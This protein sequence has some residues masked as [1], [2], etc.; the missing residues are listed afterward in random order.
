MKRPTDDEPE[1]TGNDYVSLPEIHG[2]GGVGRVSVLH[3]S[4]AGLVEW[5]GAGPDA[6]LFMPRLS[7]GGQLMTLP[8]LRWRRLDRWIPTFSATLPGDLTLTGTICAP[9]G[10]PAARGFFIRLELDNRGRAPVE[11]TASLAV[12]WR[13]SLHW[14]ATPRPL[15]GA[16]RLALLDD[17]T[18]LALET[19]GGRGPALAVTTTYPARHHAGT[20]ALQLAELRAG[21]ELG[22]GAG[23][24][25]HA[26]VD[27]STTVTPNR[28]ATLCFFIGAGRERDG[29]AAAA[30]ALRRVPP[31]Q[32]L[33]Q[34][35]LELSYTLR[36]GQDHRWA[37]LLN[38]NLLF[39]RYFALGRGIDDDRLYLLRSRSTL[40]PAPA[41]FN[42]REA[43]FWTLPALLLADPGLARE[44]LLRVLDGF[45]ERS[46]EY[47]RYLDGG[48]I[49]G[50]FALDQMLLYAWAADHYIA[51]TGDESLRDEPLLAQVLYETDAGAFSRLHPEQMLCSTE[52]LPSGDAADHPF[53][54]MGNALLWSFCET[55]QRLLGAENGENGPRLA[56]AGGEV[57]AAVWRH[58][59]TELDS[60]PI[61]ASS[62]DL[63]ESSAVYDDPSFSIGLL[64]F[65][66][67]CSA[68][69]PVWSGTMEVLR[70]RRY[71]LWLEGRTVSGLA[72]R[73]EPG[74]AR[75]AAL[76]A[77]LL[78]TDVP[79]AL[80][81]LL[82]VR[83]PAGIAAAAYDPDTGAGHE[84]HDAALAGFLA[85]TLVRAA[86]PPAARK[87][88]RA[89]RRN[90]A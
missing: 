82:L 1:L 75:L 42:E 60:H 2:D 26:R 64:P 35:R 78:G 49:D 34:A 54:T 24:T 40:C 38:R 65:L 62:T 33:R 4:L 83:L 28:R 70:S 9:A 36:A 27:Q 71:P 23:G 29:A 72:T 51:A 39:N 14:I 11:V 87:R 15:T 52:L 81:R 12:T 76:C 25:L 32:W 79:G 56:G 68:D 3:G 13:S 31:D 48:T 45:S 80:D 58:C 10:Y 57:A 59:V 22:A 21:A 66:G 73:S 86:E 16:D 63:A 67:F 74:R 89:G 41:V 7:V 90:R 18:T 46:G 44:A 69:D 61:F 50:G 85:W 55:V 53:V 77:D 19:D 17:G 47:R 84:P 20:D 30:A 6:P 37:D 43:L 88:T 5:A 8:E